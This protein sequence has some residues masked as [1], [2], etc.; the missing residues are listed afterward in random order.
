[1]TGEELYQAIGDIDEDLIA[2]AARPESASVV[3][4][5]ELRKKQKKR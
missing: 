1:M 4:M 5:E 2:E 3:S